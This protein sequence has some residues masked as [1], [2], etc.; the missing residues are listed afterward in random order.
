MLFFGVLPTEYE[1]EYHARECEGCSPW[2]GPRCVKVN[3]GECT[4]M[5]IMFRWYAHRLHAR[6]F[7]GPNP[8]GGL[9][10]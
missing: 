9:L 3:A 1:P 10:Q 7:E 2:W 5:P 8:D 6:D 4:P